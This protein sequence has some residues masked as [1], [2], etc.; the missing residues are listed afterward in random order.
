MEF[1]EALVKNLSENPSPALL[2]IA[3]LTIGYLYRETRAMEKAHLDTAMQIAPLAAK[4][5]DAIGS[6]ERITT[7]LMRRKDS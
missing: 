3:L 1:F 5:A 7:E 2:A 4:L 6:L